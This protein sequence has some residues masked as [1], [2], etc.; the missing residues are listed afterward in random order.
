MQRNKFLG[1]GRYALNDTRDMWNLSPGSAK[2]NA[3]L[4]AAGRPG[5]EHVALALG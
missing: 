5:R 3:R 4:L 1:L 2:R